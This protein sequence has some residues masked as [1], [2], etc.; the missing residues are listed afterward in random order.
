MGRIAAAAVLLALCAP[1]VLAQDGGKP[2]QGLQLRLES[3]KEDLTMTPV[4][5]AKGV[6][7]YTVDPA[8]L[9][10]AFINVGKVPIKL[11]GHDVGWGPVKFEVKGPDG[12]PVAATP[13][14]LRHSAPDPKEKDFPTLTPSRS[15]SPKW[16]PSF[17][18]KMGPMTFKIAKPGEYRITAVYTTEIEH[19]HLSEFALGSW[20][21]SVKSN[22]IVVK[23]VLPGGA[24]PD[25]T[26]GPAAAEEANGLKLTLALD[27]TSLTLKPRELLRAGPDTPRYNVE[28]VKFTA[29]FTNTSPLKIKLDAFALDVERLE[30]TIKGPREKSV[31]KK[32]RLKAM[33]LAEPTAKDFPEIAPG[34]SWTWSASVAFPSDFC[35]GNFAL[36]EPGE[37]RFRLAYEHAPEAAVDYADLLKGSW[38]GRVAS[39]EVLVKCAEE[40]GVAEPPKEPPLKIEIKTDAKEISMKPSAGPRGT[41]VYEV[42]PIKVTV[43]FTNTTDKPMKL[44]LWELDSRHLT[45]KVVGPDDGSVKMLKE[46][47][48]TVPAATANDFPTVEAGGGFEFEVPIQFPGSFGGATWSFLKPGEYRITAVYTMDPAD[49]KRS[50]LAAGS[51]TGTATSAEL[52]ID[53]VV[54]AE[55]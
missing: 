7:E 52:I 12:A 39:N 51:W 16:E 20:I 31:V 15:W 9:T 11:I 2:V 18:N 33:E 29:T 50:D 5:G 17:P 44:C 19:L 4:E 36:Q 53:G 24:A 6:K 32:A 14:G 28:N 21:N 1:A 27:K 35:D 49:C 47:I 55:K 13:S 37:Y 34:K 23:C 46:A 45:F 8:R 30:L 38:D 26:A 48:K 43:A 54:D 10:I 25:G 42:T 41:T 3:D 40:G 22:T